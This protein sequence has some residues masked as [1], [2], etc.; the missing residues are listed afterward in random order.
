MTIAYFDCFSGIAGDMTL[1]ALIDAGASADTIEAAIQKAIPGLTLHIDEVRKQGLRALSVHVEAERTTLLRTAP[2]I[3]RLVETAPLT[4]RAHT[5]ALSIM[6]HLIEAEA[7]VHGTEPAHLLLHELGEPDTIADVIGAA[8]GLDLLGVDLVQSSPVATGIGMSRGE[9]G[10]YPIPGPAVAQLLKNA[11]IYT[12]GV[13]YEL[14]TPTG[15]AILAATVADYGDLPSI[16]IQA[17]GYGAGDRDLD[18]PN[19]LRL[20]IGEPFDVQSP[21]SGAALDP[22]LV[23][24]TTIDDL[25]GELVGFVCEE[26]RRLGAHDAY[27]TPVTMKKG[28]PGSVVTILAPTTAEDALREMLFAQTTTLG[29]RR[30]VEQRWRLEREFVE[31]SVDGHLIQVKISRAPDGR[32]LH[33]SPEHDDCAAAARALGIPL[34]EVRARAVQALG[35]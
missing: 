11:P 6:D 34:V 21:P 1:G 29:I 20:F 27:A 31:V 2:N 18:H 3:R 4:P 12:R 10:F 35:H 28:R 7:H 32:M 25:D 22:L 14:V 30:H 8:V 16:R 5:M 15:A 17:V 19:V 26:A 23:L 33:A 9:H 13:P 24:E